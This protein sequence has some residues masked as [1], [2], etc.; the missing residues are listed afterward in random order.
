MD[1]FFVLTKETLGLLFALPLERFA[2][3]AVS[4]PTGLG[5]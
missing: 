5:T 3:L 1:R 4:P 2:D